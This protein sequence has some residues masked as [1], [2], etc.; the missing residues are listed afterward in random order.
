MGPRVAPPP[1]TRAPACTAAGLTLAH[2]APPGNPALAAAGGA[3]ATRDPVPGE[4][5]APRVPGPPQRHRPW[6]P[7]QARN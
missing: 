4:A 5:R 1:V 2:P 7:D 6:I 3:A